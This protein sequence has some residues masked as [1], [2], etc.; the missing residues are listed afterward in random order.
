MAED[1]KQNEEKMGKM[2]QKNETDFISWQGFRIPLMREWRPLKIEGGFRKGSVAIGDVSGPLFE[3]RWVRPDAADFD[4]RAWISRNK[5]RSSDNIASAPPRPQGFSSVGWIKEFE[6]KGSS[7]KTVWWGYSVEG[8]VLIEIVVGEIIDKPSYEWIIS[9]AI[10]SLKVSKPD[11]EWIWRIFS[12]QFSVP[13]GF[14]LE[15]HR[16]N[17]GD[18]SLCFTR[19]KKERLVMRQVYPADLAVGRRSLEKWF[20]ESPFRESRKFREAKDG[21]RCERKKDF[22]VDGWKL[23]PFPF[24][25]VRPRRCRRLA[26]VDD[27]SDR[28][29]MT[30]YEYGKRDSGEAAE[31]AM[32]KMRG[33]VL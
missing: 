27:A 21:V 11:E 13:A 2:S 1:R 18:M 23:V 14:V 26:A 22:T 10:P 9:E 6:D 12:A 7:K 5:E 30:E 33:G 29:F 20:D 17:N 15:R 25:F 32:K 16:L 28:I 24:G 8:M 19:G 31:F 3:I 4:G